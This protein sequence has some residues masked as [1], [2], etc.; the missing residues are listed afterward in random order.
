MLPRIR[1]QIWLVVAFNAV[2][3]V[4]MTTG[5]PFSGH[6]WLLGNL[7]L[8]VLWVA[9]SPRRRTCPRCRTELP[10]TFLMC[11]VCWYDFHRPLPPRRPRSTGHS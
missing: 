4:A 10:R 7:V 1:P 8:A 9:S 11:T 3:A 6:L 5:T 2:L